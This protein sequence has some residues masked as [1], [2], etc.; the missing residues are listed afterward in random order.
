MGFNTDSAG[1]A[2]VPAVGVF[3]G[4]PG[5]ADSGD[6]SRLII[7]NLVPNGDFEAA[8]ANW[9]NNGTGATFVRDSADI[10]R[11]HDDVGNNSLKYTIPAKQI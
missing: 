7:F 4:L 9:D 6:I 10:E 11:V 8:L 1:G 2:D 5:D 3:T